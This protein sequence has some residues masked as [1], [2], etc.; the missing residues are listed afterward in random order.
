MRSY[1]YS[2]HTL[3]DHMPERERELCVCVEMLDML[4]STLPD[5]NYWGQWMETMKVINWQNNLFCRP[6]F[7]KQITFFRCMYE[8]WKVGSNFLYNIRKELVRNY[9]VNLSGSINRELNSINRSSCKF[10]F[11]EFSNSA[12]VC[13]TCRVLC[14]ALSIKG[15]TLATF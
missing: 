4:D 15:K 1:R 7:V 10:F 9:C 14:F 6:K 3:T 12:Q 2:S 8:K 11:V 5:Q 13:L